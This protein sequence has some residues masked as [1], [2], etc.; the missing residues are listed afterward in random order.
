MAAT[1]V[2]PI[3][4]GAVTAVEPLSGAAQVQLGQLHDQ[5]IMVVHQDE[6]V[7]PDS[8]TLD[9]FREQLAKVLSIP[10]VPENRPPLVAPPGQVIPS[11]DSFDPQW[12][13]HAADSTL[14][15]LSISIVE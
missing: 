2:T 11:P 7:Q 5:M 14:L 10:V 13:G 6:R 1:P 3:E 15:S 8:K 9:H 12:S 4:P